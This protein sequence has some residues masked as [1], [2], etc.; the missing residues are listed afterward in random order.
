MAL[1][2]IA[3][4]LKSFQGYKFISLVVCHLDTLQLCGQHV[5]IGGYS[6]NKKEA[7]KQILGKAALGC[8]SVWI[9][10]NLGRCSQINLWA[11][12]RTVRIFGHGKETNG[13]T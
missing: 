8:L 1:L 9:H 6:W 13:E 3:V 11:L 4:C 7:R 10:K 5:R 2:N 12:P